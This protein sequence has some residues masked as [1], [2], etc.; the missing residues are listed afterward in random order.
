MKA[1]ATGAD[2]KLTVQRRRTGNA[3]RFSISNLKALNKVATVDLTPGGGTAREETKEEDVSP[4]MRDD[5]DGHPRALT[6]ARRVPF[7]DVGGF[8]EQ[9][10]PVL[11]EIKAR[12][13][14]S[15]TLN[16]MDEDEDEEFVRIGSDVLRKQNEVDQDDDS[17]LEFSL[18]C[19]LDSEEQIDSM[20]FEDFLDVVDVTT[21]AVLI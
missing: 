14:N 16:A 7:F 4:H 8:S 10:T 6:K 15:S 21:T 19:P 3:R 1:S 2:K 18:E 13:W 11:D 17:E 20:L 5:C 12:P 9:K